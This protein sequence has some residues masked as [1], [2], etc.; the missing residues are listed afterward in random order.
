MNPF[1]FLRD[2]FINFITGLGT[3]KDPSMGMRYNYCELNRNELEQAYRSNWIAR[4]VVNAPAEDA[5]KEWRNWQASQDEIEAI[6]EIEKKFRIQMLM[7]QAL[8]KARLYG[9]AALVIGVEQ[10]NIDEPLDLD[11]VGAGDLKWVVVM[12][13]YELSA[14]PRIY[15]VES[16]WYTRPEYYMVSTPT[17]NV[18][19]RFPKEIN[20]TARMHPSRVIEFVGHELPDWR[21]APLGGTWGDSVIQTLDETLKDFGMTLG[22]IANMVND[23]KMDVIKIPEL[24]KNIVNDKYAA[25]LTA[26]FATANM[27]KSSINSLII[28]G[29]E[30]WQ[31]IQT[32]F[33]GLPQILQALL[34]IIAA[35]GDIPVSRLMGNAPGKGLSQATSGGEDDLYNYYD[36]ITAKQKNEY[37]PAM[38]S[39][40]QVIIRTALGSYDPSI[41]YDWT[42]LYTPD[43]KEVAAINLQKAQTTQTYINLGLINEDV[44]RKVIA[45]Q[46]IEDGVYPGLDD[47]IDEFGLEP[48]EPEPPSDEDIQAHLGMLQKSSQQLKQI[49]KYA[50]DPE[51]IQDALRR[52]WGD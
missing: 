44:M 39:L 24:S 20:G 22:G 43:P 5:T 17:I 16:P 6:E 14:G 31:R 37:S 42:P 27:M 1:T 3:Q 32:T 2:G 46:L 21:L 10:G 26:R 25:N 38:T 51:A 29:E 33:S 34:P 49:G 18:D 41:Y 28:D 23:A 35:A 8:I 9:G 47:A 13:R 52:K 11:E 4:K 36:G 48:E 12:H 7:R 15:D 45:N 50:Q 30:E 40:D 19:P